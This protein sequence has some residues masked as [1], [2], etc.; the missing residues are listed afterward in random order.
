MVRLL[1]HPDRD[2][3]TD[4]IHQLKTVVQE[5]MVHLEDQVAEEE[6]SFLL[7]QVQVVDQEVQDR[8]NQEEMVVQIGVVFTETVEDIHRLVQVMLKVAETD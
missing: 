1:I 3:E 7:L 6:D 5:K 2:W 4:L 8:D